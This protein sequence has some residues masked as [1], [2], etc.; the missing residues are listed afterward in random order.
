MTPGMKW[1]LPATAITLAT[2]ASVAYAASHR[3]APQIALDPSA[4][5]TDVYA[6]VSYDPANL[7]RSAD[8]RKV[9][10]IE[11][12]NP[13]QDPADGPN[14]FN[15]DDQVLYRIHVD[16]DTDGVADD[17]VYEFLF[18]T[19][20]RPIG[21]PGGLTSPVPMLGNPHIT[22]TLPLQGI[23]A[24]DGPGSEGLTRRQTYKVYEVRN[25]R[26][27]ELFTDRT[28]VA[29]PSNSGP[30][31]FP[32]YPAVAAQGVYEDGVSGIR[33]FAGQRAETFYIDLGAV[34]DTLNLRRYLPTLTG[35]NEDS[36][37]V[38]PFGNNRFSGS[39]V[40]S[41]ARRA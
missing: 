14:Y 28:L 35:A 17:V 34:F 12:V 18:H 32:D 10:L 41:I 4:D 31:T 21:G 19:E 16:N 13:G 3:E 30:A 36:D 37:F 27:S 29:V 6:F 15:F 25:G 22:R 9:T 1:L 5:N 33:V 11:N 8:N 2:V 26:R 7:A 39:N 20:N 40:T 23:T 38:N 24:L